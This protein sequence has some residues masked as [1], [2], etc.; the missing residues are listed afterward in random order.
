MSFIPLK[1]R[2]EEGCFLQ[3]ALSSFENLFSCLFQL[4]VTA[5][6]PWFAAPSSIFKAYHFIFVF[7]V[8]PP[9]SLAA[10][11]SLL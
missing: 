7:V 10:P 3:E 11:V 5:C 1:L 6:I 4:L 8:I 9:S 2:C